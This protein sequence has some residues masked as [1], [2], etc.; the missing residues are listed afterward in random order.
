MFE[1]FKEY[2]RLIPKV[3]VN[4]EA[5][6]EGIVNNAKLN[7]K[8]LEED[9]VEEIIKRRVICNTCPFNSENAK[10]SDEYKNLHNGQIYK[11]DRPDLHCS[12]CACNIEW[13]TAA[14]SEKCGMSY[15]NET[16]PNN[17]QELF[18]EEYK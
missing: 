12:L 4:K 14:L 11:T 1:K 8:H 17:K 5:F 7:N 16:N 9:K 2:I 18:W 3:I 15:Y 13:K 10:H 6:I